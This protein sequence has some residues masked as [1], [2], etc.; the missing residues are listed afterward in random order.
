MNFITLEETEKMKFL[1]ISLN[2]KFCLLLK[3][4]YFI[5]YSM[6]YVKISSN[7]RHSSFSLTQPRTIPHKSTY[8]FQN[9]SKKYPIPTYIPTDTLHE[10]TWYSLKHV[11]YHILKTPPKISSY[12]FNP[13]HTEISSKFQR[14]TLHSFVDRDAAPCI[15]SSSNYR[16]RAASRQ[17]YP[18]F[19]SRNSILPMYNT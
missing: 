16:T 18:S 3:Q 7:F 6:K 17:R 13:R 5:Q 9:P 19:P 15:K 12:L 14:V 1:N 2:I 8:L 10:N 4:Q 11:L